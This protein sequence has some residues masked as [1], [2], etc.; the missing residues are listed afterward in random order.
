MSIRTIEIKYDTDCRHKNTSHDRFEDPTCNDCRGQAT[1][2]WIIE[3][4]V[5][6]QGD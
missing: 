6:K 5:I 2:V 4:K 3:H 1:T